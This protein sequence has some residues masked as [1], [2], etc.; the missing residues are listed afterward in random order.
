[1]NKF[2]IDH[3]AMDQRR[4][5]AEWAARRIWNIAVCATGGVLVVLVAVAM[6]G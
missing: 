6:G 2:M 5:E 3:Y 1:M 4:E